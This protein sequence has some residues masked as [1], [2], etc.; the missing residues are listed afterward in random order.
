M[1]K[2]DS[3]CNLFCFHSYFLLIISAIVFFLRSDGGQKEKKRFLDEN[4]TG[5]VSK[6][7][8]A[9]SVCSSSKDTSGG[10][11]FTCLKVARLLIL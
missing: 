6:H 11:V 2:I 5:P 10:E 7:S 3:S 8:S 1:I 9:L 4:Y